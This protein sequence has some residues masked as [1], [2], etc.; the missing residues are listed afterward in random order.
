M[1][2]DLLVRERGTVRRRNLVEGVDVSRQGSAAAD[3]D[4]VVYLGKFHIFVV[5]VPRF[6]GAVADDNGT[7][8]DRSNEATPV[9]SWT[10]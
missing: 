3:D 1:L 10:R 4:V 8:L 6:H 5:E 2:G 9:I 7:F